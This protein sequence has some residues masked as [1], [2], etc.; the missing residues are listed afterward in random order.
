MENRKYD[1]FVSCSRK[2]SKIVDRICQLMK[3]KQI[4]YYWHAPYD[5]KPTFNPQGPMD[6]TEKVC[7]GGSF[8]SEVK[9]YRVTIREK[10]SPNE[11]SEDVGLRLVISA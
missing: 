9:E 10:D 3:Q 6:G 2:D 4:V 7:C 8:L 5:I 11:N 1:V